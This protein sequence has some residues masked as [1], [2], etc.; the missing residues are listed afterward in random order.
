MK[1]VHKK[2]NADDMG[3]P[4]LAHR[5]LSGWGEA[6]FSTYVEEEFCEVHGSKLALADE[7]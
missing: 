4:L 7:G 5:A 3:V 2:H 1:T 6:V